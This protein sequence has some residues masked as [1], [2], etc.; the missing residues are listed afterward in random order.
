MQNWQKREEV[1]LEKCNKFIQR[2][3]LKQK[4]ETDNEFDNQDWLSYFG[5]RHRI[6]KISFSPPIQPVVRNSLPGLLHWSVVFIQV[7][8][9]RRKEY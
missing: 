2:V 1:S 6:G 5:F 4:K 8:R 9:I 7:F 3:G